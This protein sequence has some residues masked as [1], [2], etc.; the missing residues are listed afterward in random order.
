MECE[1][2]EKIAKCLQGVDLDEL[3]LKLGLEQ[4]EVSRIV[5]DETLSPR[6]MQIAFVNLWQSQEDDQTA[7][8]LVKALKEL[9]RGVSAMRIEQLHLGRGGLGD[10]QKPKSVAKEDEVVT[11]IDAVALSSADVKAVKPRP[12][13]I[14]LCYPDNFQWDCKEGV[15]RKTREEPGKLTVLQDA[16]DILQSINGAICPVTVLRYSSSCEEHSESIPFQR[17]FCSAVDESDKPRGIWM[18]KETFTRKTEIGDDVTV[19]FLE[20]IDNESRSVDQDNICIFTIACLL[21]SV[22]V[23]NSDRNPT[24]NDLKRLRWVC[25]LPDAV[26]VQ[27]KDFIN[28]FPDF[29][30]IVNDFMTTPPAARHEKGSL[31]S[32]DFLL[33]N[34][35]KFV[36]TT[37][38]DGEITN[39]VIRGILTY[40]QTFDVH[41]LKWPVSSGR[42]LKSDGHHAHLVFDFLSKI[43]DETSISLK[44]K[45]A[46]PLA[47]NINAEMFVGLVKGYLRY[48][49][50]TGTPIDVRGVVLEVT[51]SLMNSASDV[52]F[53]H[54]SKLM[55]SF[56]NENTPCDEDLIIKEHERCFNSALMIFKERTEF[57]T[58]SA[59]KAKHRKRLMENMV[60]YNDDDDVTG[61]LFY[62]CLQ[63]NSQQS[64]AFCFQL[65]LALEDHIL[66]PLIRSSAINKDLTFDDFESA[67]LDVETKYM[68]RAR[69]PYK[70]LIYRTVLVERFTEFYYEGEEYLNKLRSYKPTHVIESQE[71]NAYEFGA[72][73]EKEAMKRISQL[74]LRQMIREGQTLISIELD[75]ISHERDVIS[76][77]FK[78]RLNT[79]QSQCHNLRLTHIGV[80]EQLEELQSALDREHVTMAAKLEIRKRGLLEQKEKLMESLA[81]FPKVGVEEDMAVKVET[82]CSIL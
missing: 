57:V 51:T 45:K 61:G 14:P 11:R 23:H 48:M 29:S 18:S 19:V 54:Y 52:A 62:Q 13:V 71:K 50:D 34:V 74:L 68:T 28:F 49:N 59:L 76:A 24:E 67:V 27:P 35:L 70:Y 60:V 58:D 8:Y 39:D 46:W 72:A 41:D 40:F 7:I 3:G 47:G 12:R 20:A 69:G 15:L 4:T 22:L 32:R 80:V 78:A 17:L 33:Q 38:A 42:D 37:D 26:K 2:I 75:D 53:L 79:L 43:C 16:V 55:K 64:E 77:D 66:K 25:R 44:A 31:D 82:H 36:N 30:W 5:D 73:T 10:Q 1:V 56:V 21:S 63:S 6:D 81:E 65:A 9:N